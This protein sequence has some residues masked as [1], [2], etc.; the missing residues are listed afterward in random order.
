VLDPATSS[1][2][3]SVARYYSDKLARYGATP[4]GVD[5]SSAASQALRFERLL[6]IVDLPAFSIND[7]GCGYGALLG[8]LDTRWNGA[9]VDYLG[10]DLAP[11]MIACASELWRQRPGATF[12][13]APCSMRTADYSVASGT[14]NVNLDQPLDRWERFVEA[15]LAGMAGTSRVGVAVNFMRS[16]RSVLEYPSPL[17]RTSPRRWRTFFEETLGWRTRVSEGYGLGEFTLLATRL[18]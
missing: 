14:F 10:V 15:A 8:H 7:V 3:A 5:W 1:V 18:Q 11:A 2:E 12:A 4:R 13:C 6:E 9:S 17:Y 16:R